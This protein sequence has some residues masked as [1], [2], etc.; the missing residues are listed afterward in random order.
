MID[1]KNI[2]KITKEVCTL[3]IIPDP[4]TSHIVVVVRRIWEDITG[5]ISQEGEIGQTYIRGW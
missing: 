4:D 2:L 5:K 1:I 3:L